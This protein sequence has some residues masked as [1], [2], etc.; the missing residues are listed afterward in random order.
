MVGRTLRERGCWREEKPGFWDGVRGLGWGERNLASGLMR[1]GIALE[2]G[3][4]DL[5]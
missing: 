3:A 4:A 2:A 5:G 1:Q